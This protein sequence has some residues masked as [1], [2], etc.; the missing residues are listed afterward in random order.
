MPTT[1]SGPG[2]G[3]IFT[4][5]PFGT[6]TWSQSSEHSTEWFG[7]E[8]RILPWPC[9]VPG[10]LSL[11]VS[12]EVPPGFVACLNT[13]T[14][15]RRP[16]TAT[17]HDPVPEQSPAQPSNT[18]PD[19]GE[20][21]SG[22][23]PPPENALQQFEPQSITPGSELVTRPSPENDTVNACTAGVGAEPATNCAWT[24][25]SSSAV[26]SQVCEP[27]VQPPLQAAR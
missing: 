12:V 13:A 11:I 4:R 2:S 3:W 10:S 7:H 1:V 5:T 26:A 23:W 24:C 8:I 19:A 18:K 15:E 27:P 21:L 17:S 22:T 9:P 20:A 6:S 14:T 16:V 25:V